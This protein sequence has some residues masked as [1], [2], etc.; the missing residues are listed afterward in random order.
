MKE[1]D[2]KRKGKKVPGGLLQKD[3]KKGKQEQES[4]TGSRFALRWWVY[5]ERVR[6]G[7]VRMQSKS[8]TK[9]VWRKQPC[10]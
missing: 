9:E 6:V 5:G 8:R 2:T 1:Y 4:A 3:R 10:K 7:F